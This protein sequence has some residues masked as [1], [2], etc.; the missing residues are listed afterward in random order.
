MGDPTISLIACVKNEENNLKR[1]LESVQ[2]VVSE[3]IIVDTGSSDNTLDICR[4]KKC[5]IIEN[6]YPWQ[7]D[8]FS[9][10]K[11]IALKFAK[12][13]WVL[14]L[15]ADE[16][17]SGQLCGELKELSKQNIFDC[18][19]IRRVHFYRDRPSSEHIVARFFRRN[20]NYKFYGRNFHGYLSLSE[21]MNLGRYEQAKNPIYHYGY[22][23]EKKRRD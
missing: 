15:D 3:K 5:F 13:D 20:L 19:M 2:W 23:D 10:N 14:N 9:I 18:F 11:N 8:V 22:Y 7:G 17:A 16:E 1:M 4:D 21:A 6:P 12:G